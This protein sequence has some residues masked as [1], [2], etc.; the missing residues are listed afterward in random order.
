MGVCVCEC[1]CVC[2]HVRVCVRVC[3][4]ACAR[5]W[6]CTCK[7]YTPGL[8]HLE[9]DCDSTCLAPNTSVM[10]SFR[11]EFPVV[12][13]TNCLPLNQNIKLQYMTISNR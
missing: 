13:K 5:M 10:L 3:V 11:V 7:S 12:D 8:V 4:R 2:V 9:M 1:V 6:V